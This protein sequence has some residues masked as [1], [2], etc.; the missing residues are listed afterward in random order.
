MRRAPSAEF[1][2]SAVAHEAIGEPTVQTRL[3]PLNW[4]EGFEPGALSGVKPN[5]AMDLARSTF[6]AFK[7]QRATAQAD[8]NLTPAGAFQTCR[9][10]ADER[11]PKLRVELAEVR[12]R[13]SGIMVSRQR[14]VDGS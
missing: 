6:E 2:R 4:P 5:Q 14:E 8:A 3:D 9:A 10:F 11:L 13:I 7:Q 1:T 12:E